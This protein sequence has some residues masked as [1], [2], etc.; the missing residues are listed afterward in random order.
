VR[1]LDSP[2]EIRRYTWQ[3][4]LTM[5]PRQSSFQR[6]WRRHGVFDSIT[7]LM[8]YK[9]RC[10]IVR[11]GFID[12]FTWGIGVWNVLLGCIVWVFV[13]LMKRHKEKKAL[14]T[15]GS[16]QKNTSSRVLLSCEQEVYLLLRLHGWSRPFVAI[17]C[18]KVERWTI[19][20]RR[21]KNTEGF[22]ILAKLICLVSSINNRLIT[23][24]TADG[25]EPSLW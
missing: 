16:R 5:Q 25:D 1:S 10:C 13:L 17:D 19:R 12:D 20:S 21:A 9:G 8:K 23:L 3:L 11:V 2:T 22:A 4:A 24:L 15:L 18:V 14:V 7:G 6:G